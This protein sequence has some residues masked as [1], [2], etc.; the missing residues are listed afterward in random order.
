LKALATGPLVCDFTELRERLESLG[1]AAAEDVGR[2]DDRRVADPLDALERVFDRP[3]RTGDE[4]RLGA[5]D[6]ASFVAERR[7]VVARGLPG[8]GE[9]AADVPSSDDRNFHVSSS[10][11][12]SENAP[13]RVRLP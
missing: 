1:P 10:L 13:M 12:A 6:V 7:Y 9:A 4:D 3:R 8:L 2:V 5:R 11:D